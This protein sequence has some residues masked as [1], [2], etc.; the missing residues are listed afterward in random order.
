M[1]PVSRE[2]L[3]RYMTTVY[4][5]LESESVKNGDGEPAMWEGGIIKTFSGLGI[6]NAHY[7][8]VMNTMY[9]IGSIVQVR[10]G[11]RGSATVIALHKRPESTDLERAYGVGE[12]RLTSPTESDRLSQRV[13]VLEGRLQGIDLAK[14]LANLHSRI[15][16]LE[17]KKE[18]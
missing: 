1:P 16:K 13:S 8:K 9:E 6:S 14:T 15:S 11:A 17:G 4:D 2:T 10:R 18:R 3:L 7:A 5:R 12:N